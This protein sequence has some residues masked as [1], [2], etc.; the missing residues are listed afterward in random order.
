MEILELGCGWGSLCL[1]IAQHYPRCRRAGDLQ[2]ADQREFI[3]QVPRPRAEQHRS[4][5]GQRRRVRWT[6]RQFDRVLSV[7]MFEHVRNYEELLRRISTWLK[8]ARQADGSHLCTHDS[9]I[10]LRRRARLTGWAAIFLQAA[11]CPSDNLLLHF[12][13]DLVLKDHWQ[14]SGT[15]LR[16]PWKPGWSIMINSGLNSCGYQ[17]PR[18][19]KGCRSAVPTV[20]GCSSWRARNSL[21]IGAERLVR[22][23]LPLLNRLGSKNSL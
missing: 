18:W 13:R 5:D 1:W 9:P 8:S 14:F 22:L 12:Q 17:N 19:A 4:T 10:R 16:R 11:S 2:F 20:G 7:E 23:P 6:E 21:P 15:H 3:N